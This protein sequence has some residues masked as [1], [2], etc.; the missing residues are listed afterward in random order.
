ME[1]GKKAETLERV[2]SYLPFLLFILYIHIYFIFSILAKYLVLVA[3]DKK[4][5]E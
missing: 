3:G 4:I 5:N 2:L 1:F